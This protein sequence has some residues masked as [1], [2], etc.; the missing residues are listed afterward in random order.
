MAVPK[1]ECYYTYN[2]ENY[3]ANAMMISFGE[4]QIYFSYKTPIAF[5][6]PMDGW[7]ARKNDWGPTTRKHIRAATSDASGCVTLDGH[8]FE[9]ALEEE[10]EKWRSYKSKKY[11]DVKRTTLEVAVSCVKQAYQW[12]DKLATCK[13]LDP[14][15]LSKHDLEFLKIARRRISAFAKKF[16]KKKPK[17]RRKPAAPVGRFDNILI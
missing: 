10:I 1:A 3:G 17:R 9:M 4:L 7:F 2:H 15:K 16:E 8:T 6:S 5:Y 14:A 12:M 13:D 11:I